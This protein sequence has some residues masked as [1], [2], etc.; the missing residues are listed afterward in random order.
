MPSLS[1][2]GLVN[3]DHETRLFYMKKGRSPVER[4][5]ALSHTERCLGLRLSLAY[6]ELIKLRPSNQAAPVPLL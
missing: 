2:D 1:D 4:P 5:L 3:G 6:G